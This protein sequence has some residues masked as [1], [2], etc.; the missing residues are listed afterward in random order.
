MK[1]NYQP[2][3]IDF[4]EFE[5]LN[6]E[7]EYFRFLT[8]FAVLA[9]S[10]HNSQPWKFKIAPGKIY[11]LPDFNRSLPH[12]DQNHRQLY[13][14]IGCALENL[15]LAAD[16]YGFENSWIYQ[17]AD[18]TIQISLKKIRKRSS[19]KNHLIFAIP[20]RHTNRNKYLDKLPNNGLLEQFEGYG[21]QNSRVSFI[22]DKKTKDRI[23]EIVS[24]ALINTMD[25]KLF[26]KELSEYVKSNITKSSL[27]MPASGFG[28]PTPIS[29]LAPTLIRY[30]NMN[31]LT[32][33]K[34]GELLNEHTP[35]FGIISTTEDDIKSWIEAGKLYEKIALVAQQNGLKTAPMAAVIQMGEFYKDLQ[36]ILNAQLRPQVFFRL[37]YCEDIP[38]YSPRLGAKTL[39][40][41]S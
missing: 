17:E 7:I 4:D 1:L 25:D 38:N 37:G 30:I 33:K 29:L 8:N 18:Q 40:L 3:Q 20:R 6:S 24:D 23:A 13:I 9:P 14:S 35:V 36:K 5:K 28:I 19:E 12:S 34:D 26:R 22:K 32:K 27:G 41:T 21:T 16:Y 15:L 31:K 2:W 39:T 11:L 10:S